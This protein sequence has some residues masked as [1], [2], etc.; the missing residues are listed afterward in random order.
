MQLGIF[1][2]TLDRNEIETCGFHRCKE[3]IG[4]VH[5]QCIT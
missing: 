2:I 1:G 4:G 5:A 3:D